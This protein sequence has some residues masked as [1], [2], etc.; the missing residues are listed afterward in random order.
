M[1]DQG[2]LPEGVDFDH[3]WKSLIANDLPNFELTLYLADCSA[4]GPLQRRPCSYSHL[5]DGLVLGVPVCQGESTHDPFKFLSNRR[6]GELELS[7]SY[8][9][10]ERC[11]LR[12]YS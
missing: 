10:P 1:L 11:Q 2:S 6:Q 3:C 7:R 8:V 5:W 12:G 4:G 9:E